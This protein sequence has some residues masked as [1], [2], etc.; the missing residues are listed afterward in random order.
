MA[1]RLTPP[2]PPKTESRRLP[3]SYAR[4]QILRVPATRKPVL[5]LSR[6]AKAQ[7]LLT[8][9]ARLIKRLRATDGNVAKARRRP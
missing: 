8:P 4:P 6:L 1:S 3:H 9:A 2:I 5:Q 7:R